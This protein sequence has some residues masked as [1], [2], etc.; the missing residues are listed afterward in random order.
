[1]AR[2]LLSD[3]ELPGRRVAPARAAA[4]R[5]VPA[6][7]APAAALRPRRPGAL[8]SRHRACDDFHR[9][10]EAVRRDFLGAPRLTRRQVLGAG[11]GAGLALYTRAGACRSTR[12]LE[13]A[14]ADAAAAPDAPGARVGVPARRRGPA[15][16]ARAA[17]R[18]RP[19]R[20]PAPQAQGREGQPLAGTGFGVHPSLSPR[21]RRRRQGALRA[22]QDRLPAR[23][24][25]RQPR[26]LPLPLAPLLGDRPDHRARRP[27]AGSAA[28]STAPAGATTRSRA[29][30]MGY[31]LSPVLRSARA[32][33]A[34]VASPGDARLLDPRRVGR[35]LRRGDGGLRAARAAA[36]AA[37]AR[38]RPRATAARLAKDVADRLEPLRGARRRGPARLEHRL[39]G[40]ERLRHAGCATSR[41]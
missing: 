31:G 11:L 8:M 12:V 19:L 22:R 23:H 6:R 24:R 35:A 33:V 13:A 36:R 9:S 14:A 10:S 26:P 25:L 30:R 39:S 3:R 41:R 29:S 18:L 2:R 5:H 1:M 17:A 20:R 7:A 32:P 15:R 38:S 28:G 4:R 27:R 21:H 37:G 40:G 34:A 16:H